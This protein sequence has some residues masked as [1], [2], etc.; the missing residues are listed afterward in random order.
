LRKKSITCFDFLV[1]KQENNKFHKTI[2]QNKKK[3]GREL[4]RPNVLPLTSQV[5]VRERLVPNKSL[6]SSMQSSLQSHPG[7]NQFSSPGGTVSH[8]KNT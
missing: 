2:L 5:S 6:T 1:L 8:R 3:L 4:N 7:H